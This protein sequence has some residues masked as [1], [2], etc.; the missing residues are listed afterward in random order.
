MN[1]SENISGLYKDLD[2]DITALYG[3]TVEKIETF[4]AALSGKT[5]FLKKALSR[6]YSSSYVSH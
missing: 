2:D 6:S 3:F 4:H 5:L 1:S